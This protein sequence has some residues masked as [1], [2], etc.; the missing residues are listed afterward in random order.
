MGANSNAATIGNMAQDSKTITG[1]EWKCSYCSHTNAE[2]ML[3]AVFG[4]I[5]EV[6]QTCIMC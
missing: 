6:E 5:N 2:N 4:V 3:R 1:F